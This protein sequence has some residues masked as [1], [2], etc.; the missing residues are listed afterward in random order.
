MRIL[1]CLNRDFISNLAL[2]QLWRALDNHAFDIVL[3]NGIGRK[4]APK[5]VEIVEWGN[6]E[7]TLIEGGLF[8]L[9]D[10]RTPRTGQFQSF[11]Q[12]ALFSQSRIIREFA[13]INQDE[14]LAYVQ[15]FQPDVIISIRFGQIF[16]APAI[17]IPPLG[18]IN[19]HSG[20]LPDY[21]GILATFWAMLDNRAAI[22]CTLHYI[23]DEKID[24]GPII[25]IHSLPVDK[26]RSLL[27]N[28][29]S[30][31]EGGTA[32]IASAL[33][34][35]ADHRR[36]ETTPQDSTK[37]HYFSYPEQQRLEEFLAAGGR[38]YT[39]EDYQELF[40]KYGVANELK[41]PNLIR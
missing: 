8:P 22:G 36:I 19:L 6:L 37:S 28:V 14:G 2:N 40:S 18:I 34:K 24:T 35:L 25:G 15:E 23:T 3:S 13:S 1:L 26:R 27:W 21:Q 9:L 39:E 5:A 11:T 33:S 38:L 4:D 31:Y 7:K 17:G 16:K 32:M 20:I 12:M 10:R 30:L 29:A 41:I